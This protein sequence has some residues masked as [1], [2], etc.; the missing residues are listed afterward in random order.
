MNER[1]ENRKELTGRERCQKEHL[2]EGPILYRL[3]I[4]ACLNGTSSS[5]SQLQ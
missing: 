1:K 5:V 3:L 4:C 2:E